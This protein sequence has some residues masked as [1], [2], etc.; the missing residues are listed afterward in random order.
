MAD[1]DLAMLK[2]GGGDKKVWVNLTQGLEV[3]SMLKGGC[4]KF[5]PF[6]TGTRNVLPCLEGVQ[7]VFDAQFSHFVAPPPLPYFMT[8]P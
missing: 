4:K 2:R 1:K 8:S 7:T 5:P 6:K 3:L